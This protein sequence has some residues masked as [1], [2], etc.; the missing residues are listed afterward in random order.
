MLEQLMQDFRFAIRSLRKRPLFL[1]IPVLSL[2][3]GIGANTAIFTAV[4]HFLLKA[5]EGIPNAERV[6]ELG[7]GQLGRGFDSFSYPDFLDLR[8]EAAPLEELAG[9]EMRMLTLSQGEAGERVFGML[10]SAN[11]FEVL[12]VRPH[13]GRT[14]LP[15]E[16]EGWDEHPVV[17]LGHDLWK[18]RLGGDP[19]IVGSTLYVSRKP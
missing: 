5:P 8:T 1:L 3:V 7:R 6:V 14:F 9:Y 18:A 19:D 12:G 15:E 4:D 10:V 17:I 16:D 11:Y 2:S 13:L